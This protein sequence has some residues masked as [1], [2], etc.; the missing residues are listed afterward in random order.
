[1]RLAAPASARSSIH[2]APLRVFPLP[3]PAQKIQ[4]V[5][6]PSGG[7][8]SRRAIERQSERSAA[9]RPRPSLLLLGSDGLLLIRDSCRW[10]HA[11]VLGLL[12][13]G[14]HGLACFGKGAQGGDELRLELCELRI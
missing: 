4:I 12:E 2:S 14:N 3:R 10:R 5:Q 11:R 9:E 6:S 13:Y 7:N 8:C 1:M